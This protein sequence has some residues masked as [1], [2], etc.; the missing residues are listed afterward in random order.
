MQ[1]NKSCHGKEAVR[2]VAL[3]LVRLVYTALNGSS[4]SNSS[5]GRFHAFICL[6]AC[7]QRRKQF[8]IS[9]FPCIFAASAVSALEEARV[10]DGVLLL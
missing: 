3:Y 9:K 6:E 5:D 7:L 10:A 4:P 1:R 2:V 8:E